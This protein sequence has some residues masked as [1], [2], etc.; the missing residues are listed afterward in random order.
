MP[1]RIIHV[2]TDAPNTGT[3]VGAG[4]VGAGVG[5][6]VGAGVGASVVGAGVG[7]TVGATSVQKISLMSNELEFELNSCNEQAGMLIVALLAL[8]KNVNV[9][10]HIDGCTIVM[11]AVGVRM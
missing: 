5:E 9:L 10:V 1:T 6:G 4:V 2:S 11:N 3:F 7:A 8:I